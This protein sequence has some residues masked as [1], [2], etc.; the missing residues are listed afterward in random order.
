MT[1]SPASGD[2]R[3]PNH[4]F[5]EPESPGFVD[6]H[7]RAVNPSRHLTRRVMI[8]Q[9]VSAESEH[10]VVCRISAVLQMVPGG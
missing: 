6:N 3:L 4:T 7:P 10:P 5:D 1:P 2:R 8:D 9:N